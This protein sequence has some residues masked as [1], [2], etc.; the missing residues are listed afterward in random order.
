MGREPFDTLSSWHSDHSSVTLEVSDL[1]K[2]EGC[3]LRECSLN[4][5][6]RRLYVQIY[7]PFSAQEVRHWFE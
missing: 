4:L 1:E 5:S 3:L 7:T 6:A 2:V